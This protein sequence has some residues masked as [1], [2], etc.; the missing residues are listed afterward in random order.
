MRCSRCGEENAAGDRFCSSCGI[1]LVSAN[2]AAAITCLRCRAPLSPQERFCGECGSPVSTGELNEVIKSDV[3]LFPLYGVTLGK[4][5][6]EELARLGEKTISIDKNTGAPY[7][8]YVIR[9]TNFWYNGAGIAEH[10]YIARGIYPIPEQWRALGFDWN[11][12]YRQWLTLLQRLRYSITVDEPP[13]VVEY[14][15]HDSFSARISAT[16][17]PLMLTLDFN[18]NEGTTSDSKKTLYSIMVKAP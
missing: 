6:V 4:T 8:Y 9:A 14:S 2:P 11:I 15:G 16:K 7:R 1:A 13:Q 10:I 17:Q 18:Y 3:D 12:S 5:T